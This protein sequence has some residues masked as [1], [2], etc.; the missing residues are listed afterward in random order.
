M[1]ELRLNAAYAGPPEVDHEFTV[2]F[3]DQLADFLG[4]EVLLPMHFAAPAPAHAGSVRV[5]RVTGTQHIN[6]RPNLRRAYKDHTH[7]ASFLS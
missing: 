7:I 6:I 1:A 2:E 4:S 3:T 5:G